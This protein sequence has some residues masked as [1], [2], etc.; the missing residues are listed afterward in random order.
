MKNQDFTV[1]FIVNKTPREAYNA[2]N[3]VRGWWSE[4]I[5]G[6]TNKVNGEFVQKY[7]DV[8]R[9]KIKIEELLPAEKIVWHVID[10]YFS[11][12]K[13]KTEWID[14]KIVFDIAK[15]GTK[16]EIRFTHQGLVPAYECY[17]VCSD[18]WTE[19][20]TSDLKRFIERGKGENGKKENKSKAKA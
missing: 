12:T 9:C 19:H 13:D 6:T 4:N 17:E 14:T 3:N 20:I 2:I 5:T 16:T 15:K 10:N 8:H 7:Q 1:S 18:A 11:F